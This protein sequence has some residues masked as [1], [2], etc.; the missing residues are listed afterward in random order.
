MAMCQ[1]AELDWTCEP[2]SSCSEPNISISRNLTRDIQ[3]LMVAPLELS[4]A[5][6]YLQADYAVARRSPLIQG[7]PLPRLLQNLIEVIELTQPGLESFVDGLCLQMDD[8]VSFHRNLVA[9]LNLIA[10]LPVRAD[11]YWLTHIV[12]PF[13]ETVRLFNL[14]FESGL[15]W[16]PRQYP[17]AALY[18]EVLYQVDSWARRNHHT[19]DQMTNG[20]LRDDFPAFMSSTDT[21]LAECSDGTY[22]L[23]RELAILKSEVKRKLPVERAFFVNTFGIE[24]VHEL[25]PHNV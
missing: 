17:A 8:V 23:G 5:H 24:D 6:F 14:Y 7:G 1:R 3:R 11:G 16:A 22:D 2:S 15:N 4:N 20:F 12:F 9:N 25:R 10:E 18:K 13:V 21:L 19:L